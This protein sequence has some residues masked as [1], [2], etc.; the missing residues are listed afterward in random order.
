MLDDLGGSNAGKVL[1]YRMAG[2]QWEPMGGAV[3][4]VA[5]ERLGYG[6]AI[7]SDGTILASQNH[8]YGGAG[9]YYVHR[10][11]KATEQW[12]PMGQAIADANGKP[13]GLDISDSGT[14][15]VVG[16][17]LGNYV[18]VY[19]FD[20]QS[21]QWVQVGSTLTG[22]NYFGRNVTINA[23]GDTIGVVASDY[24]VGAADGYAEIYR[25]DTNSSDWAQAG[26]AI[27]AHGSSSYL[28]QIQL[29]D[30]GNTVALSDIYNLNNQPGFVR[31]YHF[32]GD[33]NDWLLHGNVISGDANGDWFGHDLSLSGDGQRLVAS[34]YLGS[35]NSPDDGYVRAYNYNVNDS[36]WD[37]AFE[38]SG[39]SGNH[40]GHSVSMN[41]E[42]TVFAAGSTH[43]NGN[44]GRVAV[45]SQSRHLT[46]FEDTGEV[47]IGLNSIGAG[48]GESQPLKVTAASDNTSLIPHPPVTYTS[49][50]ATG[51]LKFTPVAD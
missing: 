27:P 47:Q 17:N 11:H 14:R 21:Q 45:F 16:S 32:D 48:G 43:Y 42:G 39:E 15:I 20:E 22:T 4:G 38:W 19:D 28:I 23:G 36:R 51:S 33:S 24:R 13:G 18:R 5:G 2:Q 6:V 25:W 30:D 41:G 31:A 9:A 46:L 44:A 1:V 49:A 10:F 12:V 40:F 7:N 37:M 3:L 35:L 50:E 8:P 26:S 34:G 29:S